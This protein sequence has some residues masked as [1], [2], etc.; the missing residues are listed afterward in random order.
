MSAS[1]SSTPLT[2]EVRNLRTHFFTRDGVL[3]AVDDVSVFPSFVA[4]PE[5]GGAHV[6]LLDDRRL[7]MSA[8]CPQSAALLR[9]RELGLPTEGH[10][11]GGITGASAAALARRAAGS[12]R[13]R[14]A[15]G[16]PTRSSPS[17]RP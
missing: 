13:R 10:A 16:A 12:S 3:P 2:L 6:V 14:A 9:L 1:A 15:T 4:M 11:E 7:L 5:E 8:D 17:S